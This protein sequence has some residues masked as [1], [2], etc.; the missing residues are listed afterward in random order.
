MIY[1][2]DKLLITKLIPSEGIRKEKG[3][4]IMA[5]EIT[6]IRKPE[7]QD[8]HEAISHYRWY[9]DA[10]DTRGIDEREALIRWMESHNTDAYVKDGAVKI[11]CDIRKNSYGTKYLQTYSDNK[12]SN[13]LLSLP[14]C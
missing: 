14:Q 7:P 5:L 1:H 8:P 2:S 4:A 11:W 13:N 3:I 9:D 12:Y 10:D 6:G